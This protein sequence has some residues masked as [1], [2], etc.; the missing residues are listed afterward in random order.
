MFLFLNASGVSVISSGLEG[1]G[2]TIVPILLLFFT[3][4]LYLAGSSRLFRL[5]LC[6]AGVY[7][8]GNLLAVCNPEVWLVI[9]QIAGQIW[10]LFKST[11]QELGR[12]ITAGSLY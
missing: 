9:K 10:E 5:M 3:L 11:L 7:I 4:V 6:A 2:G 12:T 8:L 1:I